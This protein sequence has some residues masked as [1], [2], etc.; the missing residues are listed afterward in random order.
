LER[1]GDEAGEVQRGADS[2]GLRQHE[3]GLRRPICTTSTG[4]ARRRFHHWKRRFG[5]PEVSKAKWLRAPEWEDAKAKKLLAKA[6]L[7]NAAL[8]DLLTK[9]GNAGCR[10]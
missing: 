8:K 2:I 7:V 10:S 4:S 5:G 3:A 9:N 6:H 1:Q